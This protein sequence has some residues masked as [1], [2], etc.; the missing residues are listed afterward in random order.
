[1][2]GARILRLIHQHVIDAKVEL[3][4]HPGGCSAFGG[5]VAKQHQ[6]L[7]DQILVVEQA[8]AVLFGLITLDDRGGDRNQGRTAVSRAQGEFACEQTAYAVLFG[9]ETLCPLRI[10][11]GKPPCKDVGAALALAG[12]K[13]VEVVF[14]PL[15]SG[16][17]QR[18]RQ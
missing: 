3:V 5:G 17:A 16:G 15:G 1:L 8:A 13:H 6:R 12:A 7:V 4:E 9:V 14:E 18:G 2:L 10:G 11:L